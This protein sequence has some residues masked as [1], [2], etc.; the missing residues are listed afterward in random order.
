MQ[1]VA[2]NYAFATGAYNFWYR[3]IFNQAVGNWNVLLDARINAPNY[4][5]NYFGMGND[6]KVIVDDR[7]FNRVRSEQWIVT[8][9]LGKNLGKYWYFEA[10]PFYQSVEVEKSS[11][12]FVTHPDSKLDSSDFT[13]KRFGGAQLKLEYNTLDNLLY[14]R[15]GISISGGIDLTQN[16]NDND[17]GFARGV[18]AVS[19]YATIK[20]LTIAL[21]VGT[22]ANF[23]NEYEFYQANTIG[24]STNLRGYRRDRFS[25]KTSAYQNTELRL[26]FGTLNAYILK[27]EIGMLA[28]SDVGRVWIPE[29]DSNTWHWGYGGG[30]WF[31]PFRKLAFTVTYGAST[32][33]QLVTLKAGFLF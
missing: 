30:L 5:F 25:G 1:L 15:K 27:G 26:H 24:G 17:R 11:D 14:P 20:A 32:E 4:V 3:G 18:L 33:D 21:R 9:G 2:G 8:A 22:A 6:T 7:N 23:S 29:E 13:K 31:L 10:L 16:I 19:C 12:R 28:F